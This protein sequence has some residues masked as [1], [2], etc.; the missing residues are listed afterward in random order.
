M[1]KRHQDLLTSRLED[2]CDGGCSHIVWEELYRWYDTQ[3]ITAKT[4][5]DLEERWQHLTEDKLGRLMKIEGR[6]GIF[7]F[8]KGNATLVDENNILDKI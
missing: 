6:G 5:R 3:K 7:I 2:A 8:A 1:E 4:Y